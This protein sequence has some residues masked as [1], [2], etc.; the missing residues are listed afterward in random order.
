MAMG[1]SELVIL[2]SEITGNVAGSSS[3]GIWL[4]G[5]ALELY[6][7][8]VDENVAAGSAGGVNV[9]AESTL[10]AEGGSISGN[11]SGGAGGGVAAFGNSTLEMNG[12]VLRDNESQTA[13]GALYVGASSLRLHDAEVVGNTT[14]AN[15]GG[16]AYFTGATAEITDVVFREN[17]SGLGGGGIALFFESQL[18]LENVDLVGNRTPSEGNH[19]GGGIS[20]GSNSSLVYVGGRVHDNVAAGVGGGL[21]IAF[22]SAELR[23]LDVAGNRAGTFGGGIN[24][25]G[26]GNV[27]IE[28]ST[29][30]DNEAALGGGG[31][32]L[33][34][35]D[36]PVLAR[37]LTVSG[38]RAPNGAGI[39]VGARGR[40]ENVT[41]VG[42]VAEPSDPALGGALFWL[43]NTNGFELANVLVAGNPTGGEP[44]NCAI[45]P[46]SNPVIVSLGGNLSDDESC[47]TWLNAT[48][49]LDLNGTDA[50]VEMELADNGGPTP[51]HALLEGSAAI[52]AGNPDACPATDQRGFTRGTACDI[53]AFQ[54]DGSAPSG[55]FGSARPGS[56]RSVPFRR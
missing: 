32:S 29:A 52:G 37:N 51:T 20:V 45:A 39:R 27:L 55:A 50:G 23:G 43:G 40:L 46:G 35:T 5:A 48:G 16:G 22:T 24:Q 34:A 8:R 17:S 4:S 36:V 31:V 47:T 49:T 9:S 2:D 1:G 41:V 25:Q 13:G 19:S 56:L 44:R 28:A 53:G 14:I 6:E 12:V 3:G 54:R 18:H 30:R 42:N 10:H 38:N 7:T 11:R 21:A 15:A 33:Q 26:P